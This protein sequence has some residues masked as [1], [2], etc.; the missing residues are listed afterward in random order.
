MSARCQATEDTAVPRL[1][2]LVIAL[3][4]LAACSA[5]PGGV[6]A[7]DPWIRETPPGRTV[8]AGY[9][10][11]RN[12]GTGDRQLI[13]G[14]SAAADRVEVHEMRHVDGMMRMRQV[15]RVTVP[16]GES[17]MLEPGG[18]HLMLFGIDDAEAGSNI[19]V[20]LLFDDGAELDLEFEVRRATGGRE[21]AQA[22]Q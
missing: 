19:P 16:A 8:A 14:R 12:D 2:T 15:Q 5:E 1:I 22:N 6:S 20:T 10:A 9:V 21:S 18:M 7:E 17:V 3:L 4:L 11:L 13:G